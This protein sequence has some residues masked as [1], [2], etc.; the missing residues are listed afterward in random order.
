[1][2]VDDAKHSETIWYLRTSLREAAKISL[3]SAASW[4]KIVRSL[5]TTAQI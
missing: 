1:M 5:A 2:L 3:L 4:L